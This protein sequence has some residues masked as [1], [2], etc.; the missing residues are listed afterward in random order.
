MEFLGIVSGEGGPLIIG[1][2]AVVQQWRGIEDGGADYER[3]C[4]PLDRDA[5]LQGYA[6][7]VGNGVALIWEMQGGGTADLFQ[8]S[9]SEIVI[10]RTWLDRADDE[11][12]VIDLLAV[13]P[14]IA[15]PVFL[16]EI[17]ITS[18]VCAVL[19]S[20]EDG[21][22]IESMEVGESMRMTG[23][24][25]M[26]ESGLMFPVTPGVYQC[27]HDEVAV[28]GGTARRCRLKAKE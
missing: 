14:S 7:A 9:P 4:A 25:A 15:P 11:E 12:V 13:A 24:M 1:D 17:A 5:N 26:E 8:K 3:C 16:C 10:V 23:E 28:E 6:L 27:F 2:A 18:G 21:Q 19:W 20:P 22:C